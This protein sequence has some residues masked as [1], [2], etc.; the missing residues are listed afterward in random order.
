ML[1]I[2]YSFPFSFYRYSIGRKDS[3]NPLSAFLVFPRKQFDPAGSGGHTKSNH[4][5]C[6]R[7][8][9]NG[10]LVTSAP[11]LY[12]VSHFRAGIGVGPAFL[13]VDR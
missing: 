8:V 11:N 13:R 10:H 1:L 2:I 5:A 6:Q 4:V 7:S 12:C 9:E 3:R